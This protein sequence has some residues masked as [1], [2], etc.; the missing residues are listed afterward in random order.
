MLYL[1]LNDGA[2]CHIA[3]STPWWFITSIKILNLE[4]HGGIVKCTI[5]SHGKLDKNAPKKQNNNY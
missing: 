5:A 1:L 2:T 3:E 4:C